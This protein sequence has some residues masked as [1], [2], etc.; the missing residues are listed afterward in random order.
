MVLMVVVADDDHTQ[1]WSGSNIFEVSS[2]YFP[3][4][5]V[6]VCWSW[7]RQTIGSYICSTHAIIVCLYIKIN[8]GCVRKPVRACSCMCDFVVCVCARVYIRVHDALVIIP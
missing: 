1:H 8:F 5:R 6:I 2:E 3:S 4:C 7:E